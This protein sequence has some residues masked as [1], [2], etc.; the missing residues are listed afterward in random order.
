MVQNRSTS[1]IS[2]PEVEGA[3]FQFALVVAV[4]VTPVSKV[5]RNINVGPSYA[6]LYP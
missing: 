4:A 3:E 6:V 1:E 5:Y 2:S